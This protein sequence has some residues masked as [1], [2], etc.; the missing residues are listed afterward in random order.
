[1]LAQ[2]Q[3]EFIEAAIKLTAT[4]MWHRQSMSVKRLSTAILQ[5]TRT[6]QSHSWPSQCNALPSLHHDAQQ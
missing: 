5:Q 4:G 3:L 6:S 1:M 2:R